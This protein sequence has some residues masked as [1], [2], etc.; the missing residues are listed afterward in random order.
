MT[1]SSEYSKSC[2]TLLFG[3]HPMRFLRRV[4]NRQFVCSTLSFTS[5]LPD[6]IVRDL[7]NIKTTL[8]AA[9]QRHT[10][11]TDLKCL[12]ITAPTP[13]TPPSRRS[14][15]AADSTREETR[16][17]MKIEVRACVVRHVGITCQKPTAIPTH[18]HRPDEFTRSRPATW[19]ADKGGATRHAVRLGYNPVYRTVVPIV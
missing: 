10:V 11:A 16:Y 17:P 6:L 5:I 4:R 15:V 12:R 18:W 8:R 2:Q 3:R 7:N 1:S 14:A 13:P 9:R 19:C